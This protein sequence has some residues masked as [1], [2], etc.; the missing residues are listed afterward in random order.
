V[1]SEDGRVVLVFNGEIYNHRE[2]RRELAARGHVLASGSDAE[3][4]VHLYE[5]R[6]AQLVD[7]LRGMYAFAL[8]DGETL[9]LARD[10]L[11]IKP[12]YYYVGP[13]G[14]VFASELKALLCHPDVPRRLSPDA[15]S[16]YLSFGTSPPEDA[17]LTGV[18][19]LPP[20]HVLRYRRGEVSLERTW[21]LPARERPATLEAAAL[22]LRGLVTDAVRAH[23]AADVPVGAF[24]S[25]GVD[26]TIIVGLMRA[27]GARPRTFS[28][29]F[30]DPAFDELRWARLAARH[31]DTQHAERVVRL[32]AWALAER[33]ALQMDEPFAD[34]S[35]IPTYLVAE[36]AAREVKVVLTG[37]GGDE[38]FAGYDRYPRALGERWLDDLPGAARALGRLGACWPEGA[39]GRGWLRHA[40]LAPR[41]RYLDGQSLFPADLKAAILAPSAEPPSTDA[42]DEAARALAEQPG[43]PLARL[44]RFDTERALPLDILTKVDRATMACS[45]EARP[46]F[47]DH[48]VVEAAFRLPSGLKLHGR[49]RK[50]VLKRAFSDLVPRAILARQKRGF[51]V[52]I[53]RWF[54]G[55][56]AREV[57]AILS[58][59]RA[60]ARGLVDPRVVAQLLQRHV[61]GRSDESLRLWALVMLEL[62]CR[63]VLDAPRA[64]R[65]RTAANG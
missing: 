47:L 3:V 8:W 50:R 30:D 55:P 9:L 34:V 15:L 32:D 51:G 42:L 17:M 52:P 65:E 23:L 61:A 63:R 33:L 27:L 45:L 29:G 53:A 44:L 21:R 40:G 36:L 5:E 57:T 59:P 41:L 64:G 31:F 58:E 24:L 11:G 4:L 26:S 1:A 18:R 60:R 12:L 16:H 14:L 22:E 38:L 28:I 19:K 7:A 39:L 48:R 2:L 49:M 43:D 46:V 56:L 10:R 54:R 62:W 25:G 35:A 13:R 37:D 6:G 20:A